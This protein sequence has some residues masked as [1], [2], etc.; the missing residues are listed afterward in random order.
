MRINC[1]LRFANVS[2]NYV[3]LYKVLGGD[4]VSEIIAAS[5]TVSR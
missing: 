4:W 3:R 1:L 5:R 2:D